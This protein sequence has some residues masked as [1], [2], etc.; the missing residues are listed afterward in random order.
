[1]VAESN[2]AVGA[3]Q[4]RCNGLECLGQVERLHFLRL[5]HDRRQG[6]LGAV[7]GSYS[8]KDCKVLSSQ[9]FRTCSSLRQLPSVVQ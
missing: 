2:R 3:Q 5:N 1:V 4:L 7:A 9:M 8:R 6:E